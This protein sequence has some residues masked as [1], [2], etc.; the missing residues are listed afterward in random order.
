MI[1]LLITEG[2][3]VSS[4][5]VARMDVGIKEGRIAFLAS[6]GVAEAE[7][8]RRIDA[9]GKL[10]VPGGIDAHV[11]GRDPAQRR[12]RKIEPR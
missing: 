3:V 10:V 7:A 11:H 9:A 8:K 6:P 5:S 1:D 12:A 4:T 2:D